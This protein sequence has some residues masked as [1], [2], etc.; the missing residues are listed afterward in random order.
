MRKYDRTFVE[1]SEENFSV[2]SSDICNNLKKK[3]HYYRCLVEKRHK[4]KE[5]YPKLEELLDGYQLPKVIKLSRKEIKALR[6]YADCIC[7]IHYQEEKEL[8]LRGMRE[9]YFLL[10]DLDLL[11]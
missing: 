9:E 4:I 8:F 5:Q 11:K 3:N 2:F 7:D 6:E 10:K 1:D